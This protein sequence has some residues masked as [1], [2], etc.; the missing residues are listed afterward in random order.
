[1][2]IWI[3]LSIILLAHPTVQLNV[4]NRAKLSIQGMYG[5]KCYFYNK[6][7]FNI[8]TVYLITPA[9]LPHLCATVIELK[10][11]REW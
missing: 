7:N 8:L 11:V 10:V 1:M 4:G 3:Q 6:I 5:Y 2:S 9:L